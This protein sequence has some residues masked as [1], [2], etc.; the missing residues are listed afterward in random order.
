MQWAIRAGSWS[1]ALLSGDI[2]DSTRGCP[3]DLYSS[4][5][6]ASSNYIDTFTPRHMPN[7]SSQQSASKGRSN[8]EMKLDQPQRQAL[9]VQESV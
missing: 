1:R 4:F 3:L 7:R 6:P 2:T 8:A 5:S 9:P